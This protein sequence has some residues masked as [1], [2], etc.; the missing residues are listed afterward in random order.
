MKNS[1]ISYVIFTC[2]FLLSSCSLDEYNEQSEQENSNTFSQ[3]NLQ[4]QRPIRSNNELIISFTTRANEDIR[5]N[6]RT[7]YKVKRYERC[8]CSNQRIEKWTF[9]Q[10]ANIEERMG[11]ISQETDVEGTDFQF[12]YVNKDK[13]TDISIVEP[14][15]PLLGSWV[16]LQPQ[17]VNIGVLDTGINLHII[18]KKTPF[19]YDANANT[20][21]IENGVKEVSGWDFVNDD[22]DP[23]DELGHGTA[24]TDRIIKE[25]DKT[26][27]INYSILPIKVF[28][29]L[30]K[31][32]TFDILC[33]Y[34]FATNKGNIQVINM[35]FG[36]Y[37]APSSLLDLFIHENSHIFHITS[38]G[39]ENSNND[40]IQHYP[41][42]IPYHNV[43]AVGSYVMKG[44]DLRTVQKSSFS[45]FGNQTVD[46]LSEGEHIFFEDIDNELYPISGTSYAAP[47]VSGKIASYIYDS[48]SSSAPSFI[49]QQLWANATVL[50][51]NNLP[52]YYK[53]RIIK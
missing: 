8:S 53:D 4:P 43:V 34:L 51:K 9:F 29:Q 33:G 31:G 13:Q 36:W 12:Y 21:C 32:N 15:N 27:S 47:L 20:P 16:N 38:S 44:S 37:G 46:Y 18:N 22:N 5:H 19:L 2:L 7:K 24:V 1:I 42:S 41:S 14:G 39:N 28:D 40:K 52:V 30:G 49:L 10:G 23:Y 11:D 3:K 35:S 25:L 6:L 45:N 26:P 50:P 48:N 17:T